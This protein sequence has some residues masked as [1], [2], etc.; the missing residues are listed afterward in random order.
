MGRQPKEEI[1]DLQ[2][3]NLHARSCEKVLSGKEIII[4]W[5]PREEISDLWISNLLEKT[6]RSLNE[7][8][9]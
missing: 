8:G 5:Q 1:E 2:I 6:D 4:G 3:S 7:V 9:V